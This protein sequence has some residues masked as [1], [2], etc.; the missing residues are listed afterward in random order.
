MWGGG[1]VSVCM[2]VKNTL[3]LAVGPCFMPPY[4]CVNVVVV[5]KTDAGAGV[6]VAVVVEVQIKQ[7]HLSQPFMQ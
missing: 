7:P 5:T 4:V 3:L 1:A 2:C 6:V